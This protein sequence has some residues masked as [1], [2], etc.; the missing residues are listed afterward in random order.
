MVEIRWEERISNEEVRRKIATDDI[1]KR[2]KKLKW[3]FVGHM[4][5]KEGRKWDDRVQN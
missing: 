2:L 5:R 3:T 1:G 4:T